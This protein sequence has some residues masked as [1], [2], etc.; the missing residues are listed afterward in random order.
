[1]LN[2]DF[3]EKGLEIVSP[4]FMYDFSTKMFLCCILLTDQISLPDCIYFLRYWVNT[5]VAIVCFSGC[6]AINFEIKLIFLIK[7][8]P[9]MTKK[10]RQKIKYLENQKSF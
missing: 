6:V 7:L 1:M 9:Y 3:L 2:N 8:F 4:Q 5:R 10:S